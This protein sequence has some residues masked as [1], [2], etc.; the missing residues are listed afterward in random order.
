MFLGSNPWLLRCKHNALPIELQVISLS[1]IKLFQDNSLKGTSCLITLLKINSLS[2][3]LLPNSL[4]CG[5]VSHC[6]V[7]TPQRSSERRVCVCSLGPWEPKSLPA[8]TRPWLLGNSLTQ[9]ETDLGIPSLHRVKESIQWRQEAPRYSRGQ[10]HNQGHRHVN[11]TSNC[12][13]CFYFKHFLC[14]SVHF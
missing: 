6:C 3:C 4:C 13:C 14:S 2:Y 11:T 8:G 7:W 10:V 9:Q 5:Y 1:L 12:F